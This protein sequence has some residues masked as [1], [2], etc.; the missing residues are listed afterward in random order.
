MMVLQIE[1]CI[2][3]DKIVED[4][5]C[6]SRFVIFA[7]R[8]VQNANYHTAKCMQLG[9]ENPANSPKSVSLQFSLHYKLNLILLNETAQTA[10]ANLSVIIYFRFRGRSIRFFKSAIAH[11]GNRSKTISRWPTPRFL[12]TDGTP[13]LSPILRPIRK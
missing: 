3:I 2:R 8:N 4:N 10:I 12:V 9:R 5:K 6:F 11:V 1:I 7:L 13:I